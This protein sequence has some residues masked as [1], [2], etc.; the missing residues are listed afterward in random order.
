MIS[1]VTTL[2]NLEN[3]I[4][5]CIN[6]ILNQSYSDI[7]LIIVND[8]STDK[9][10]EIVENYSDPRIKLINNEVNVGAGMSRRIGI[11]NSKG[12]HIILIDGDDYISSNYIE[13]LYKYSVEYN[14]DI[15]SGNIIYEF[16]KIP[17]KD[18]L[19]V[20]NTLEERIKF[21]S[22][23]SLAFINNKLISKKLW[24]KVQYSSKRFIEDAPTYDKLLFFANKIV[25]VECISSEY[26]YYRPNEN[27][28]CRSSNRMKYVLY[29]L[30]YFF[31]TYEFFESQ[32]RL[33][34]FHKLHNIK[35]VK[36]LIKHFLNPKRFN[37]EELHSLYKEDFEEVMFK[38][39]IFNNKNGE[40]S[41]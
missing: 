32:N 19:T 20:Y 21:K 39:S 14:A 2:Y 34:L 36:N 13:T 17:Q 4:E 10:K 8:C 29:E 1:V 31:D 37:E 28:L 26:Y 35:Y 3:Y 33:D 7:E 18:I 38:I 5:E 11:E 27:G 6:S 16:R 41:N 24:D 9:S 40:P 12:D 22:I 25:N 15:V 23:E 30:L